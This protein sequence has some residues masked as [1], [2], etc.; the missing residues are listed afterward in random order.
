MYDIIFFDSAFSQWSYDFTAKKSNETVDY[1]GHWF[2]S[3]L[4]NLHRSIKV[5][6]RSNAPWNA[7]NEDVVVLCLNTGHQ[8]SG[9]NKNV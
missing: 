5:T 3:W 8:L 6:E 2:V 9:Q 4:N 7:I 1:T